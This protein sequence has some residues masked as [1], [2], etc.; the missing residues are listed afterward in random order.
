[1][2]GTSAVRSERAP[3][4][5]RDD[6]RDVGPDALRLHLGGERVERGVDITH[7]CRQRR[8]DVRVRVETAEV[9]VEDVA[10]ALEL[11]ARSD[12]LGDLVELHRRRRRKTSAGREEK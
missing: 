11:V 1:M 3:E 12:Q 9:N 10:L 8:R 2:I 4:V 7:L 6:K 5:G